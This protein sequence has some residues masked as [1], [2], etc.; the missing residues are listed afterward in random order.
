MGSPKAKA[1]ALEKKWGRRASEVG[2]AL[3]NCLE[4]G[5]GQRDHIRDIELDW[6]V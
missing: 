5:E 2:W 1:G 6:R 3:W 4:A